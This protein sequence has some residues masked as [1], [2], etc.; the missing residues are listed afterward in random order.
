MIQVAGI[1]NQ[2]EAEMLLREGVDLLGFPFALEYHA[3]DLPLHRA[4][5]LIRELGISNR[6]VLITYLHRADEIRNLATELGCNWVQI[7][8]EAEVS[9]LIRLRQLVPGMR[10]IRSLVLGQPGTDPFLQAA[11]VAPWVH[12]FLTDS[13]DPKTGA[14]GATGLT[15]DWSISRT[16]V[17]TCGRPVI[18]AGGLNPS[19]VS[20]AIRRVRPAGVDAHTGLENAQGAKDPRLVRAFV[21][22][23]RRNLACE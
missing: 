6:S 21:R 16:L 20:Q 19:N 22:N 7:H 17:E 14:R 13:Y 10:V 8:G 12:A 5:S 2:H 11:E 15:H 4:S 3:E 18:L 9:E 23:V 1:R